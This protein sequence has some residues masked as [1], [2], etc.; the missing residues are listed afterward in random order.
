ME[1]FLGAFVTVLFE[2]LASADLVRFAR[3]TGIDSELNKWNNKLFQI[4]AVLVDAGHKHLTHISVQLW[5]N[6]LQHVAYDIDDILD[7]LTTEAAQRQMNGAGTNTSKV[8]NIIPTKFHAFKYGR[9]MGSKLDEI[10]SKLHA[11]VEEKNLLGLI[12]NIVQRSDKK[13]SEE[14]SLV[15]VTSVVG[16][17]RDQEIL[18]GKLLGNESCSLNFSVVSIVG[19]G[20]IGKTTLAQVLYNN[21]KVKDH[22]QLK[23]WVCVS[24]EFDV[25]SIS[26]AIFIDVGGVDK[27]FKTLNQLQV[28]LSEK[29]SNK[30]FLLVL[31]DVWNEDINQWDLL[32]RPFSVA[33]PGSKIIVT[34]RKNKVA[35]VVDSTQAYPLEILSNEEA[36]CLLAQNGFGRQNFN[37]HPTFKLIGEGIA[38]RC[39]RLPLA[40]I[41]IGRVLRSKTNYEEWEELLNSEIWNLLNEGNILPALRLSYYDLPPHLKQMFAYCCL[42]PKGYVFHMHELVLLWMAEGFL[43]RSNGNISMEK[44]GLQCFR[45][46]E[47]RSFFQHLTSDKSRYTMHDLISD[48]AMNVAGEFFYMLGDNKM[49]VDDRKEVLEKFRHF[50]FFRQQYGLYKTFKALQKA[51][52][53]R[54]CLA[55]SVD[56]AGGQAFFISNKVL[57]EVLPRLTFLRVLS[58]AKYEI[59]EVPQSIGSL[60]HLRYLNFSD[61][62]ITSLPEKIGDLY[63]LQT[64]LVPGCTNL[65]R[66][67]NSL[68][69]LINLRYLN[70]SKT[71]ITCLP[72][73]V[74]NLY[75]LQSLLL[76]GCHRFSS[77]PDSLIKL[78]NLRHLEITHTPRLKELPM[79]ICGLIGLQTLSKVIIGDAN[80]FKISHL[81]DLQH[82][83]GWLTIEGLHKLTISTEAK[84]A[85]L[86]LKRG[87]RDLEMH[88]GN[89]FD[90]SRNELIE[91]EVLEGLRPFEKL[92]NIKILNYMGKNFPSWLGDPMYDCL[93]Q[94][95]LR[96][97][98]S[99]TCLPTLGHL[100]SLQKLLVESMNVLKRVGLELIETAN[101]NAFPSL[102][103]LEFKDMEGWEEWSTINGGGKD[104]TAASFPCLNEIS[105]INCP[106]LAILTIEPIHSLR[107]LYVE[108]C[109]AVA[110]RSMIGVSSKI[111]RLTV[112][113]VNGFNAQLDGGVLENLGAV[114]YLSIS[115]C[116]ELKYLWESEAKAC[117]IL[118]NLQGLEV[119]RCKNLVRLGE[120]KEDL[121]IRMESLKSV[122]LDDCE[123][124]ESYHCGSD[125][126]ERLEISACGSMKS[127]I[128]PA[129]DDHDL[130]SPF[131]SL[132]ISVCKNVEVNWLLSNALSSLTSL[133][134]RGM[135]NLR[136]LPEECLLHL[137]QL[138][139]MGCENIES[140]PEN[141]YG[142]LP[143]LCLRSLQI[144]DCKNIKSFPHEQLPS[145]TSL[146]DMW[147]RYCPSMGYSFPGG[148]W[149]PNLRY[150]N[151]GGL[152]KP[153]SEWGM[154]NF[155]SSLVR[156]SL[157]G[158]NSGMVSFTESRNNTLSSSFLLPSSLT[159]L[160]MRN[161]KELETVSKG[162]EHLTCLEHLFIWECRKLKDLPETLLPSLSSLG[163]S[164]SSLELRK[165]CSNYRR[166]GK[167]WRIISQIPNHYI[168]EK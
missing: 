145:L 40:L 20:G 83:Q 24:D 132:G 152:K 91:F 110:L 47:S 36:L 85:N 65:S 126:I 112:T 99:C 142:F 138:R 10:T 140:I 88:W 137:I 14:T 134:I 7:D 141:G 161:F 86:Q 69:K 2:K 103:V 127:L 146:T 31:D 81:K 129:V 118:M 162:M 136:L 42:I 80:G 114:E 5:L 124:L 113:E 106:K 59:R 165:K 6:K 107:V 117:K 53:L 143:H 73:Q 4:E 71:D 22:F 159:Y 23:S 111:T 160:F 157:H 64:L 66:L 29:L 122:R 8:F 168:H 15:D 109:S 156:L 57:V 12:D 77:F 75:N 139:I 11:L 74:G 9:K 90:I 92:T 104:G 13:R 33:A 128:F 125:S 93:T 130:S 70:I 78:I 46:L 102:E 51:R 148:L 72:E 97:C 56:I 27:N 39:G 94:I 17:E 43:H 1:V 63:N 89:V 108:R 60:K 158:E 84:E 58:L 30:R 119:G 100:P 25:F 115:R 87:L 49:V 19:L 44:F 50:S 82:L 34:T 68:V 35:T 16:R 37:S 131:K 120:R 79:G 98:R 123:R 3:S 32:Q 28:A 41:T 155:P 76:Y 62:G 96:G 116:D 38:D 150:L 154:Q 105:I 101:G 67:P 147:I 167:Y 144:Y 164:Y 121:V 151:I 133:D 153:M 52:R 18:L 26:M 45:E 55:M 48:L 54:T 135:P 21:K 61:T 95:T 163:V 149:P 166:R